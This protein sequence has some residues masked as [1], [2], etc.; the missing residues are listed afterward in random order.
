MTNHTARSP[1]FSVGNPLAN[2]MGFTICWVTLTCYSCA[3]DEKAGSKKGKGWCS[4]PVTHCVTLLCDNI[5]ALP[6][7]LALMTE[8]VTSV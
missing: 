4:L 6:I 5:E 3:A 2:L 8:T 1:E 7:I